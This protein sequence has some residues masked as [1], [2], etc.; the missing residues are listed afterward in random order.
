[1]N[2]LIVYF[3]AT[4]N[5]EKIAHAVKDALVREGVEVEMRDITVPSARTVGIDT[6]RYDG[7]FFGFPVH[8]HRAPRIVREWLATLD[9]KGKRCATFFT[10]G[11]FTVHP[12]H[13]CTR[14]QLEE[15]GFI[16]VSSAEFPG[17]HTFNLGGWKALPGR[18]DSGDLTLAGEYAL[19]TIERFASEDTV[20]PDEFPITGETEDYLDKIEQFRFMVLTQ[21]PTRGGGEC[22][23]CMKCG[24]LCPSGAMDAVRG[25]AAHDLCIACLGCMAVCP[26]NALRIN[27]MSASWETK[28][29][30]E[31]LSADE[32]NLKQGKLYF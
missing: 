30:M 27:D 13:W 6:S 1:M 18:P 15:R 19:H 25:E 10:Y 20:V 4:G 8:S 31:K 9:G 28:L 12:C 2:I 5:T 32:V 3:S 11:G 22:S 21:V 17:F 7:I 23:L 14:K 29:A 24:E 26:E 16:V